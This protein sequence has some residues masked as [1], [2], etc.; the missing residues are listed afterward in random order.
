MNPI[1]YYPDYEGGI[2]KDQHVFGKDGWCNICGEPTDE[3]W[4]KLQEELSKQDKD[5]E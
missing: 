5:I 3:A 1:C 4:N 2:I